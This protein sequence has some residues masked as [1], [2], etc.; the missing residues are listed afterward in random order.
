MR[1][2][3]SSPN[4]QQQAQ[5]LD[6]VP[7]L[8]SYAL[9][10]KWLDR[11]VPT[12]GPILIDSGAYS[13]MNSGA[14]LEVGE[15]RE[16]AENWYDIA[17]AVAGLDDIDGDWRQGLENFEAMPKAFPTWHDT[18]PKEL[19]P[20]L[21]SMAEERSGWIGIGLKPPREGKQNIVRWAVEQIP[22]HLHVHGWALGIYADSIPMDS[23]DATTWFRVAMKFRRDM[24]WLN[25]G[26]CLDILVKKYRRAYR[27]GFTT[28][29]ADANQG[30]LFHVSG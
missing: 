5:A 14:R 10:S 30:D 1:V 28:Q 8:L 24:P 13:A 7:T 15:Y 27:T 16:W 6:E 12:F 19:L 29:P 11:Y 4:T 9:Y 3:L 20:E 17:D 25:Y 18:D 26:E 2:Y 21:I 22:D 23:Y